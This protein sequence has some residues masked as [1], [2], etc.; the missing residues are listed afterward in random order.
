MTYYQEK[1]GTGL[2]VYLLL[3]A[4][5]FVTVYI[6][7]YARFSEGKAMTLELLLGPILALATL[8][9]VLNLLCLRTK[10]EEDRIYIR[11]GWLFPMMWRRIPLASIVSVEVIRYR[12]LRDAG[13]W[14]Y[15]WGR[16]RGR[17]CWY[18]SMRGNRGVLVVTRDNKQH[19]VGSQDAEALAQAL[20]TALDTAG[21]GRA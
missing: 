12:P 8:P 4:V 17:R 1:Q 21:R 6:P 5:G 2:W 18:Y 16:Y 14:G 15:R 19:V 9:L 13:G 3:L 10:V 11:L 7:L 20:L